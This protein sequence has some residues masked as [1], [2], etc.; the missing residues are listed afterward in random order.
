MN[1]TKYL[2][3]IIGSSTNDNID[4]LNYILFNFSEEKLIRNQ[5]KVFLHVGRGDHHYI[6]HIIPFCQ[7]LDLVNI[8]YNIDVQD[9]EGHDNVS[10]Y[11]PKYL[12]N[13]IRFLFF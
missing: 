4:F 2:N 13:T 8:R 12:L 5:T 3:Y 6:N 7:Y 9:Y 11:F 1:Q 10:Q